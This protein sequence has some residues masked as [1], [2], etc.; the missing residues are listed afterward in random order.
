MRGTGASTPRRRRQAV[1]IVALLLTSA[2]AGAAPAGPDKHACVDAATRG[3]IQRD[4]QKLGAAAEAFAI[5]ASASCPPAVRASCAEWL[6]E[7]RSKRPSVTVRL[8][9]EPERAAS[10][11]IDGEPAALDT[12]VLLDPG[13]HEARVEPAA[14]APVVQSF[15]LGPGEPKTITIALPHPAS[16]GPSASAPEPSRPVPTGT[17]ILGGVAV[18]GV[19]SWA[20]FGLVAKSET[21]RLREECAPACAS[22]DRDGA[23]RTALVADVSLG[24]GIVAAALATVL[25]VTR[26]AR[27]ASA[28]L[29]PSP[30]GASLGGSF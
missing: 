28:A 29:R 10:L 5:C 4:D 14:G 25:Y 15:S 16:P 22:S 11:Y 21:D 24:V 30:R 26:P 3:Q 19:A 27:A 18:A 8:S 17:W 20:V 1:P 23:F 13:A 2:A 6:E 9:A 7:A 12:A